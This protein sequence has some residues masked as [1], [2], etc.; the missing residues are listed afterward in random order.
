MCKKKRFNYI[1]AFANVKWGKSEAGISR[2][3]ICI[4]QNKDFILKNDANW[5]IV[6][7]SEH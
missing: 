5:T 3:S 4:F 7:H 1:Q 6:K 2:N